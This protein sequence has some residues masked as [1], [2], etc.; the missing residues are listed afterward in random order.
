[1]W[2]TT[3]LSQK[4]RALTLLACH[5][6]PRRWLSLLADNGASHRLDLRVGSK[7]DSARR[8]GLAPS[9]CY[10]PT[11][12]I[13]STHGHSFEVILISELESTSYQV[14]KSLSNSNQSRLN[15]SSLNMNQRSTKLLQVALVSPSSSGSVQNAITM[16]CS[17]TSL[18]ILSKIFSI[19]AVASSA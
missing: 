2:I 5:I 9:V 12:K 11:P 4:V 13:H 1:M 15:I 8:L 10:L 7:L 16:L 17:L 3:L 18:V 14:R 6:P 19:S